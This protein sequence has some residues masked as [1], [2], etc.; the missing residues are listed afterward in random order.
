MIKKGHSLRIK[1]ISK[2]SEREGLTEMYI[3]QYDTLIKYRDRIE[4]IQTSLNLVA[5]TP[6]KKTGEGVKNKKKKQ[7]S[8]DLIVYKSID[9]LCLQLQNYITAK[10]AGNTGVDNHII[11][12]L[13]KLLDEKAIDRDEYN[14]LYNEIFV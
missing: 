7:D 9:D 13:D 6:K 3:S 5:S 14:I 4:H 11:T 2:K 12:L 8:V 1:K 10:K